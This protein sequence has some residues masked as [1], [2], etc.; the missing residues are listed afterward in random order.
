MMKKKTKI[1]SLSVVIPAFNE[2]KTI[3]KVFDRVYTNELVS[4]II[5]VDDCSID[6]TSEIIDKL[7]EKL[8]G[9]KQVAIKIH[10]NKK[11]IGKGGALRRGFKLAT[12]DVIVI[13]D[14]DLEYSPKDYSW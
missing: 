8:L 12:S 5:L 1:P 13:Q 11:N 10:K 3:E 14:A 4:E 9:K 6:G 7:P 2:H